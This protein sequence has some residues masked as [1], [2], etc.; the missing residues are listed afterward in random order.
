M[1]GYG[2]I[3]STNVNSG[4]ESADLRKRNHQDI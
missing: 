3:D 4:I 1:E 2:M